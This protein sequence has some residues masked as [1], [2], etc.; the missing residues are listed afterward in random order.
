MPS[1]YHEFDLKDETSLSE[2]DE[3]EQN[4]FNFNYL[5][6]FSIICPDDSKSYKDNDNNE[7]DIIQSSRDMAPLP[8]VL[9]FVGIPELMRDV[10]D[11]R[12]LMEHRDAGGVVVFTSW[13]WGSVF[14][15]RGP[16]VRELILEFLSML[17]FRESKSERI[18]PGKGDLRDYWRIISTNGD[19]LGPPPSYTLIRDSVL[20]L[21]H[22]MM[23]H[24]IAGKSQAPEKGLTV[25]APALKV[26]DMDELPDA[27]ADALIAAEDA[28]IVNEGD[29][30]RS[31]SRCCV[32][33]AHYSGL[34]DG[35]YSAE[36]APVVNEG[37]HA[38][39][40]PVQ[41]PQPPP[42]PPAAARSMPKSMDRLEED[43]CE[44]RGELTEQRDVIDT[45]A[46]DFSR[47]TV[48]AA[49]GK[50]QPLDS[51]RFT[52]VPYFE[53]HIPYQRHVRRRTDNTI[54]SAAQ[55][56]QQQHDP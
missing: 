3:V 2:Y 20:R 10:F 28:P 27:A 11:V 8:H 47:F 18:I 24:S 35:S 19:F 39:S 26:I 22:R 54:T 6:P 42:P 38:V 4:I 49:I 29:Q 12:M 32:L 23:A 7:I 52:Y 16:L 37:D 45:M 14:E 15:T 5:F 43:V 40:A 53:T 21:C 17:R 33:I 25:I 13:A 36:D 48:W 55:Q 56:D 51:T 50:A 31:S 34:R 9:D 44:I 41:A 46:R 1:T 30:R